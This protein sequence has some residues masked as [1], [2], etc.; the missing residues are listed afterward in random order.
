MSSIIREAYRYMTLKILFPWQYRRNSKKPLKEKK[1]IFLESQLPSLS[2]SM[3]VLYDR[4]EKEGDWELHIHCLRES[5]VDKGTFIRLAMKCLEDMADAEYVFLCDASRVVSCIHPRWET[6]ITQLWHGCGAFK[7]FGMST[8]D[9]I[10]G[11]S[12][13]DY[14]K[15][16]YYKNLDYVTVSSPE[17][18]WAYEE[19]M[20]LKKNSGQ[21][22]PI[23]ISRTDV[24]F[25]EEFLQAAR[26]KV[27]DEIPKSPEKKIILYAPTFRGNVSEATA[28]DALDLVSMAKALGERYVLLIKHHPVVKKRPQIPEEA[29]D[30]A[31]DVTDSLA[32]EELLCTC[33]ICISDYS[34]LIFEYSLFER[35]LLFFAYDLKEYDDWRGFYYDYEELT[36]G[37]VVQTTEEVIAYIEETE[38]HFDPEEIRQFRNKFMSAC[39]GHATDRLI[40]LVTER[41]H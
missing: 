35:P 8:A 6:V 11:G 12:R 1:A 9:H 5:F 7:K 32:I 17:V 13:R 28:P 36:P 10:F 26:Q 38:K 31:F 39:D 20:C 29:K 23:G 25:Q 14:E 24:F 19:A 2:D 33:D 27:E 22:Q 41:R 4:L 15:Y 37:P 18:A 30:F 34:S 40:E 3:Q 16:P 21:V